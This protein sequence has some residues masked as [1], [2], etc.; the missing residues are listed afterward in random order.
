MTPERKEVVVDPD[1]LQPQHLGKQGAQ[2]LLLRRARRT[3]HRRRELGRRQRTTVELAVRRQRKPIQH[4]DRRRNHVVRK[5]AANMRPQ[6]RRI[7]MRARGRHHIA[8]EPLVAG[9]VLA[10]D[11]RRL[12]NRGMAQ[13]RRL[14]LA[15]LDPEPAQLHLRVR[16]PEEVQNPVRAPARQVPAAVHPAPRRPERVGNKPLR[17]Q[18]GAPQIAARQP[19]ARNVKLP[20]NPGR[21]RLQAAVQNVDLR[22]PYRPANRRFTGAIVATEHQ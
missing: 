5:A 9:H 18:P 1:P 14:D 20:R 12:P 7:H 19:G 6:R 16:P 21:H 8:D 11:H 17:R 4:H 22:V 2:H 10:R 15:R 3:P 13:Q